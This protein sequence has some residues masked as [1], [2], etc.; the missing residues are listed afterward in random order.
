LLAS[1]DLSPRPEGGLP[2]NGHLERLVAQKF[3]PKAQVVIRTLHER[4]G[5]NIDELAAVMGVR[6]TAA[7][8]HVRILER[9]G[10]VVRVRQARHQ[11]HFAGDTTRFERHML[12]ILRVSSVLD[13]SRLLFDGEPPS[14]SRLAAALDVT[15]RTVRRAL[16]ILAN[17][18]LLKVEE[19]LNERVAHL[20]PTLR[21][22]LARDLRVDWN[23]P[24]V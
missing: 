11:L 21:L 17:E 2:R 20:H 4:P 9:A 7:N 8:H 3:G 23:G 1:P 18:G 13:V 12:C 19:R 24:Q 6:R 5:L 10:M 22:V 16:R 15:P 14:S